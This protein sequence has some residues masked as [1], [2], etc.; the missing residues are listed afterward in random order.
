LF[1]LVL[2]ALPPLMVPCRPGSRLLNRV[3]ERVALKRRVA[4]GAPAL[5]FSI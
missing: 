5:H 3:H 4:I 1:C 2:I